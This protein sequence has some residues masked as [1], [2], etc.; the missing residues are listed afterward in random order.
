[1]AI[2]LGK[3][4]ASVGWDMATN[5]HFPSIKT[6]PPPER[7]MVFL[8]KAAIKFAPG[9]PAAAAPPAGTAAAVKKDAP[10]KLKLEVSVANE[11][12]PAG[13]NGDN[14]GLQFGAPDPVAAAPAAQKARQAQDAR[15]AK[16]APTGMPAPP[17][18]RVSAPRSG[19]C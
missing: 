12:A 10:K 5:A 11:T 19:A 2:D 15:A 9:K 16:L 18:N 17:V 8:D 13:P 4:F 14:A 3:G 7:V 1:M 6:P